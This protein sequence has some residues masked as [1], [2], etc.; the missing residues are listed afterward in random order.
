MGR[1]SKGSRFDRRERACADPSMSS[2]NLDLVRS[3]FAGR[4][5][6]DFHVGWVG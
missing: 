2:A 3:I 4:G 1:L 5:R 6:G